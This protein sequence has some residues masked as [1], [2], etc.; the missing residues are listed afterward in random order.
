MKKWTLA[1][2]LL[3]ASCQ[4]SSHTPHQQLNLCMQSDPAT[5]DSRK[6]GDRQSSMLHFLLY[7]GLTRLRSDGNVDLALAEKVDISEDMLTYTFHI[8]NS[9]WSNGDPITAQDFER[10]WKSILDPAFPAVNAHLLYP[11]KNAEAVKKGSLPAS[12]LG[13]HSVDDNT[14]VVTLAHPTPYFLE[15]ISFCVFFPVHRDLPQDWEKNVVA[16]CISSGPFLLKEWKPN[17]ELILVKNPFYHKAESIQL[18]AIHVS[19]IGSENTALQ[20]YEK[21]Q[22]DILGMPLM[23]LPTEAIPTLAKS[24]ELHILPVGATTFCSFNVH[25]FPFN[26]AKIRK[27]FALAIN[28]EEIVDNITQLAEEPALGMVPPVVKKYP[29]T[30]FFKDHDISQAVALFEEGLLELGIAR[31]QFPILTYYY[32]TSELQ[33]KVAQALQQQWQEALGIQIEL[34]NLEHKTFMQT[35]QSRSYEFAQSSWMV[36]YHDP[37]NVLER[38]KY[39]SNVKNYSGWEDP[40]Y[41]DFLSR[42]DMAKTPEERNAILQEAEE[43]LVQEMPLAPIYHWSSVFLSKSYVKSFGLAPIGNGFFDQVVLSEPDTEKC[44]R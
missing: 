25:Q 35:V 33:H 32:T 14:L 21:G 3:L 11:I 19:M 17:N 15:L 40:R 37:M 12:E 36:Q 18:P 41:I 24:K 13:M 26:N 10:S 6:G 44:S 39:A 2:L 42:S 28:R 27:A 38:Y 29:Q 16:N 7:E 1:L 31:E 4:K 8:R 5:F 43:L 9:L 22:L 30:N 34:Q 20:M 23:N